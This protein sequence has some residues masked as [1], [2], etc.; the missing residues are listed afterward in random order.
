[1]EEQNLFRISSLLRLTHI[2]EHPA[3]ILPDRVSGKHSLFE[4]ISGSWLCS[5]GFF[6]S[7]CKRG[8]RGGLSTDDLPACSRAEGSS[9]LFFWLFSRVVGWVKR[10]GFHTCLTVLKFLVLQC[11]R[12]IL[13]TS[14]T[15][16]LWRTARWRKNFR[17]GGARKVFYLPLA[18]VLSVKTE[19]TD[20]DRQTGILLQEVF[21]RIIYISILQNCR[22]LHAGIWMELRKRKYI[23]MD[24]LC[25]KN[26]W[27]IK[28]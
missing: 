6:V 5:W 1:M 25:L 15:V 16:F 17:C 8:I 7:T 24:I 27:K 20:W 2:K 3:V 18:P 10:K 23:C 14:A 26:Y 19:N 4:G 22:I 13:K 21:I 12:E 9:D 28:S 11:F